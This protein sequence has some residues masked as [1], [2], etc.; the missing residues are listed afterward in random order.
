MLRR[1]TK[2][3]LAVFLIFVLTIADFALVTKSYAST[4]FNSVFPSL[5]STGSKNVEFDAY[6]TDAEKEKSYSAISRVCENISLYLSISVSEVGYLKDAKIS[7]KPKQNDYLNF[8]V[9]S[10]IDEYY[11]KYI[12]SF[13]NNTLDFK[14][15]NNGSAITIKLDLTYIQEEFIKLDKLNK[16]FDVV[17]TGTYVNGQG[18]EVQ[19]NKVNELNIEWQDYRELN[20]NSSITK[21]IPYIIEENERR[22]YSNRDR[23]KYK[24]KQSGCSKIT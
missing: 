14:Q 20:I 5:G 12:N 24:T 19:I 6:F 10:K 2:K 11:L 21:F 15:I 9:D 4:I 18:K 16:S 23:S 22:N 13:N 17:F 8:K 7:L 1:V 3:T